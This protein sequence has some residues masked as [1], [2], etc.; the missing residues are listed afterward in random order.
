MHSHEKTLH[1]RSRVDEIG[2]VLLGP[3]TF[4]Q[5]R[6]DDNA[7]RQCTSNHFTMMKFKVKY[8]WA[9]KPKLSMKGFFS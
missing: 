7:C 1:M 2:C 9:S 8:Y 5:K 4:T 6:H 3:L